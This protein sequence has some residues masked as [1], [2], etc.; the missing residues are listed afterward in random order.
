MEHLKL[1]EAFLRSHWE[2][3]PTQNTTDTAGFLHMQPGLCRTAMRAQVKIQRLVSY[4]SPP[5]QNPFPYIST[6]HPTICG[7][8]RPATATARQTEYHGR[9]PLNEAG[10]YWIHL[11]FNNGILHNE[12]RALVEP[13]GPSVDDRTMGSGGKSIKL[14]TARLR[15]RKQYPQSSVFVTV[16]NGDAGRTLC[17]YL[18]ARWCQ[19]FW[20]LFFCLLA[21]NYCAYLYYQFSVSPQ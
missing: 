19:Y 4:S 16:H 8:L 11:A 7:A 20:F 14:K 6:V 21:Y 2:L 9:T 15:E 17:N 5:Y 12:L 18:F 10:S 13:L 3:F 1:S